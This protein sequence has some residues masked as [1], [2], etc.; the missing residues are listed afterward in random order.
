MLRGNFIFPFQEDK[1]KPGGNCDIITAPLLEVEPN[2]SPTP[3]DYNVAIRKR[4]NDENV[5]RV[6]VPETYLYLRETVKNI[7]LTN[8]V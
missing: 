2:C 1:W 7:I 4:F 6:N 5:T 3:E 8:H